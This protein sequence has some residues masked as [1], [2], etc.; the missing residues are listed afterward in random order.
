MQ[1]DE[2]TPNSTAGIQLRAYNKAYNNTVQ[3]QAR[4]DQVPSREFGEVYSITKRDKKNG[5]N[6]GKMYEGQSK[7]NENFVIV[8]SAF[9]RSFSYFSF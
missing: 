6:T 5:W 1:K 4:N 2:A 8:S 7:S 3:N 9:A